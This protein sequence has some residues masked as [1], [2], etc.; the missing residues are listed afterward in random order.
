MS[1]VAEDDNPLDC[2][3]RSREFPLAASL[4]DSVSTN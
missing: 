2:A 4:S 3:L 1:G